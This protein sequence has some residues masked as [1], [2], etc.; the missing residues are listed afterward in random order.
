[1]LQGDLKNTIPRVVLPVIKNTQVT[2]RKTRRCLSIQYTLKTGKMFYRRQ[3]VNPQNY[4]SA[5]P[6]EHNSPGDLVKPVPSPVQ[7]F[8]FSGMHY[9]FYSNKI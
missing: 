2:K 7:N 5:S 8:H 9:L 4:L 3:Q 6:L 1:M